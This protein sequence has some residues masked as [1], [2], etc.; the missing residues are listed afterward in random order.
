M[1]SKKLWKTRKKKLKKLNYQLNLK[2][3]KKK[4]LKMMSM[5]LNKKKSFQRK[6]FQANLL[7]K[8]NYKKVNLPEKIGKIKGELRMS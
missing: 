3:N 1:Y 5:I 8:Q 4:K 2:K 7:Q 6:Q